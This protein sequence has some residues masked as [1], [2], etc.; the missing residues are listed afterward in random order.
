MIE[1]NLEWGNQSIPQD[2]SELKY[3]VSVTDACIDWKTTEDSL[4][5]MN[6]KLKPVLSQR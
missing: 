4:R 3:G 6:E 1:S 2:L 5:T